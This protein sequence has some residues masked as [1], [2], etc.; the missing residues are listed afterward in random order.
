MTTHKIENDLE[1]IEST[2]DAKDVDFKDPDGDFT[3]TNVHD[4]LKEVFTLS[5]SNRKN[6]ID[7]IGNPLLDTAT[8]AEIIEAILN[9]KIFLAD[10]LISKNMQA[11]PDM[12]FE[13]FANAIIEIKNSGSESGSG[14]ATELK[15]TEIINA[16]ANMSYKLGLSVYLKPSETVAQVYK[17]LP[18]STEVFYKEDFDNAAK[19]P[20]Y[21][22]TNVVLDGTAHIQ[23]KFEYAFKEETGY[24]STDEID[25]ASFKDI[26]SLTAT[27]NSVVI[28][29]IKIN[30]TILQSVNVPIDETLVVNKINI[31]SKVVNAG[32]IKVAISKD[33]GTTWQAY[34]GISFVDVDTSPETLQSI[35]MDVDTLNNITSE[36]WQV[37]RGDST[38]LTFMYLLHQNTY[39]DDVQ[40]DTMYIEAEMVPR[41]VPA[42]TNEYTVMFDE[43]EQQY[44][45]V[46][47][48]AQ[49]YKI[50]YRDK[51]EE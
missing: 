23:N 29:A 22:R 43:V 40:L 46:F 24:F 42:L 12:S 16:T 1:K 5:D 34:N 33:N 28:N 44:T 3:A 21:D 37:Y 36:L 45:F 35:G 14:I 17:F 26:D 11:Y 49:D 20:V 32:V 25:F 7:A 18:S 31:A 15:M 13:E 47:L 6:L 10:A 8:Y 2:I 51:G 9:G 39:K 19:L 50:R 48:A 41:W 4:A 27:E 30:T 38:T